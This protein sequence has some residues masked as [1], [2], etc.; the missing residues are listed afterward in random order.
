MDTRKRARYAARARIIKALAHPSRLLVVEELARRP[1][2][3][4]ELTRM[5]G[6]DMSTVSKHLAILKAAGIVE[7]QKRGTQVFYRLRCPCV[8]NFL[9]CVEAVLRSSARRASALAR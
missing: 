9:G 3:V 8:V 7:D 4:C 6:A 5:V 2:C 1:R